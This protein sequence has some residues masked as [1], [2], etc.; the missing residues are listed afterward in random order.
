[1]KS[2]F[3]VY[4][5]C[6][7]YMATSHRCIVSVDGVCTCMLGSSVLSA[8]YYTF[9]RLQEKSMTHQ[10]IKCYALVVHPL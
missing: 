7:I 5:G 2:A 4:L 8:E 9:I 6:A 10:N 3:A 1:M